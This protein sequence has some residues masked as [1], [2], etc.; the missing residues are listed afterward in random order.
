MILTMLASMQKRATLAMLCKAAV[1]RRIVEAIERGR[2][3]GAAGEVRRIDAMRHFD[4]SVDA[5]LLV[6]ETGV[7]RKKSWPV[8]ASL[9]ARS[10]EARIAVRDDVLVADGEAYASTRHLTGSCAPEWRSG[11][12]HD[13]ATVMELEGRA[14]RWT[15]ALGEEVDVEEHVVFPLLKSSDVAN[16][17]LAPRRA[18]IVPQRTL[19][20]DTML[21]AH[22][23]PRALAYLEKHRA[24]LDA[25]K[26]SIYRARPPFS[27]FGVGAY[28]FAPW[29]VAVSGLYKR[30][31]FAVVGPCDGRPV[32]LDDTCYFLPFDDERD[33]R[34]AAEALA[35]PI[36]SDWLRA[37]V[38][39]EDK[40]P[41]RKSVL[42]A[43]DLGRLIGELSR[44]TG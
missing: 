9:S 14:G 16:A 12:K 15:N 3:N 4:A 22:T 1:A 7:E 39:W 36:M 26:S 24:R 27:V 10:P 31:S 21:L 8:Y 44:T 25:R 11:L 35:S 34:R 6:V 19:G 28:T 20:D 5:A 17:R 2:A 43:L 13:C 42:Q 37:R 40:R 29:K 18:V 41:I 23:A 33:A 32:V 38:F 30:V